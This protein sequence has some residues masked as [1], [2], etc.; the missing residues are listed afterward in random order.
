MALDNL[1]EV[2]TEAIKALFK[3]VPIK[4]VE[5]ILYKKKEIWENKMK[6]PFVKGKT[7]KDTSEKPKEDTHILKAVSNFRKLYQKKNSNETYIESKK[8]KS[9]EQNKN[10]VKKNKHRKTQGNVR[11]V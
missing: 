2:K 7:I 8:E 1:F 5:A 9:E 10:E 3:N 4:I 6:M 11:E